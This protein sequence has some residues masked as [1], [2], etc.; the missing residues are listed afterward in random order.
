MD[1]EGWRRL[2][3]SK[4]KDA[5]LDAVDRSGTPEFLLRAEDLPRVLAALKED[6][7]SDLDMLVDLVAVDYSDY[8]GWEG[9]RFGLIYHLKS[10]EKRHRVTF[11]VLLTEG[12]PE[13][14]TIGPLYRNA[15]WLEREAWDQMGV[16]FAGHPNLKRLLNHHEFEGHPLR[17]DYPITKR[18]PLATTD[19]MLD[20][21]EARLR[22]KGWT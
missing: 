1:L 16:R 22:S 18:Q 8:P 3:E 4:R 5:V 19:P 13:I 9:P 12:S 11:K 14:A 2:I 10:V 17:K 6:P 20:Q 7:V 15:D 21:M